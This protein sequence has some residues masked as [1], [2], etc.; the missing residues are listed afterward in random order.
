V[1]TEIGVS[2][3]D[4]VELRRL[5]L[6]NR[7]AK[8]RLIELTSF[9]EVAMA[10][11]AAELAHPAFSNLFVQTFIDRPRSAILCGRRP[12][13]SGERPP[14]MVHLMT[15]S[16]RQKGE[17]SFE[18]DRSI[19]LGRN[20]T[21]ADPAA[22]R[23]D[24]PLTNSEGNVLDPAIAAR[25]VVILEPDQS[26]T[27]DILTGVTETR[28]AA[29]AL[30]E[31]YND[32]RL[33][34]RIFEM[35]WTHSQVVLQHL[36]ISEADAQAYGRLAGSLIYP[37]ALRR[38]NPAILARNQR[39]QSDLWGYGI[40]GDL[41]IV[42][43][44]ISS[45]TRIELVRQAVIAH[46]YWRMK[47]L[48]A[49][50]VIWN[51]DDSGYRQLLHDQIMGLVSASPESS[52]IDKPG[53][54]FVR[55]GDQISQEDRVLLMTVARVVLD[56]SAGSLGDQIDRR[57]RGEAATPPFVPL[58]LRQQPPG[59]AVE[60]PR[61]DLMFFNGFGGFTRDGREYVM[62]LEDA[63][64]TPAPW[65]NV[66]AN[67]TF[68]TLVSESG[69]V[70]TWSENAHEFR[71]TPWYN[72]PVGDLGG[73]AFY[74]RDEDTGRFFSPTPF[75]ARGAMPYVCRHGFG[76]SIFEYVEDG[77][78][79]EL[80]L[81]VAMDAPVKLARFK[82]RNFSGRPRRLSVSGYWEWVL[83]DLRDKTLMHVVSAVDARTGALL[84][85]NAY[86][87][88]F[89]SRVAFVDC[90]ETTRRVTGDR[91]EFLGRNGTPAA[92]AAMGKARLSGRVGA[93]FDPCAAMQAP[94]ELADGQEREIVFVMGAAASE[95]EAR[96]LSQRFR[97]VSAARD[98]LQGVWN[99]WNRA[100]GT[101]WLETPEPSVNVLANGWLPYQVLSSRLWGRSGFYQSGGAFGFRDQLQDVVALLW[102][103]PSL[104]RE[105]LLRSA[106]R[107][108]EEGD[109]Q[110]WWHPPAGRGV[111]THISDDYLWLPYG[112][113]RYVA[114]TG[115]TGVLDEM[116]PFLKGRPVPPD[117][118][119][120]YDLP[121]VSP[122][123]GTL[124]EHCVRAIRNGLKFG[125]H[126]LPLM[127]CG[128]WNDGMN[129]V[130][131]EGK[132]ESVWLA[133]FLGDVMRQ[134]LDVAQKR[135]DESFVAECKNQ[136]E[137]LR[138]NIEMGAWDGQWY[139]RAY[140]DYGEA[141]G[142]ASNPE[143]QIDS[144]AQSWAVLSTLAEQDRARQAMESVDRRLVKRQENLI[145]LFDPPFD[146]SHLNPGYIKGYIP[147]VRENGGQYTHAAVWAAMAFAELGDAERAWELLKIINPIE[148]GTNR[149]RIQNYKIEPYVVAADVYACPPHVGRGG[150]SWYTGSAGWLYRLIIESLL[151]MRLEIDQLH[152]EP[153]LPAGW[154]GHK[155][156]YR[157]RE[158]FYHINF[159]CADGTK[160]I[161]RLSVD[162]VEEPRHVLYLTDDRREHNVEI[163]FAGT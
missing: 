155:I 104:T 70:Y 110:H 99:Y 147:G 141:L 101:V 127:G 37:S 85:R 140:F 41:P 47:G 144:I 157:Y 123:G 97:T 11:V 122:Q 30:A 95:E 9:A 84:A 48:A 46:A 108:F 139:R 158:T 69:S 151:G 40:S 54:I 103:D 154:K 19:F 115:D 133:F 16:A 118:E 45:I 36:N 4:D 138:A 88:E 35:A 32:P 20:R 136:I 74:I 81:Y 146:H 31:K 50:L 77:I 27:V 96:Q 12:R 113:A 142:S 58:R 114:A 129:L 86:S 161:A 109:V 68:G 152:F 22:L 71:L 76:Y 51:E 143:C 42:L 59:V 3:E 43:L 65:V 106:G 17:I 25:R 131:H 92:P 137:Q 28:Q 160:R 93:G 148:H 117:Q 162:G 60:V 44:R 29:E 80:T 18:T 6:T 145:Q 2:S 23:R 21:A 52:L 149:I 98:A 10:P 87:G 100:L 82:L 90:S 116:V 121:Q 125:A 26:A 24:G 33:C 5:T 38:A 132:G 150:W 107:Q 163:T 15:S 13:S 126:G 94:I 1:H 78:S 153:V 128:D 73:E 111:R 62:L 112:V 134:F 8:R 75:P 14:W 56:D 34:D 135:G 61:R 79:C 67:P 156:H 130:G 39:G 124:Y 83:G 105:H 102:T 72:D 53:G 57:G 66:I 119:S 91:A 63:K 120:Y 89:A 55:R 7:T 49:D 159:N 64:A